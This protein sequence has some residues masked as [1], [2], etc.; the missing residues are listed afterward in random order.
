[1]KKLFNLHL[2]FAIILVNSC[3]SNY[4]DSQIDQASISF[5]SFNNSD[6]EKDAMRAKKG[7]EVL[8]IVN[9]VNDESKAEYE[10]FM[11]EIFFEV[12]SKSENPRTQ[13]EYKKTRWLTPTEKNI[14][15]TWTYVFI[16]DP[17]VSGSEYN[18]HTLLKEKYSEGEAN[19]L[20]EQYISFMSSTPDLHS[21]YQ[22]QH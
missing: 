3:Q 9:Y 16:M 22:T 13:E 8:I 18:I 17:V 21:L 1:M 6:P 14:N 12:L 19:L 4:N 15:N 7:D 5:P 2:I 20:M 10:K 11:K